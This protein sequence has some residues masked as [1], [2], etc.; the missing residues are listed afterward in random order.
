M[1]SG[2]L[3]SDQ[4]RLFKSLLPNVSLTSFS[5]LK[6]DLQK[7]KAIFI[8]VGFG[9]GE[10]I[11]QLATLHKDSLFIGCEAFV[12]G[13][14]AL[15]VKIEKFNIENIR[16]F[17]GDARLL[18]SEIPDG[19]LEG[20]F[21]LFPDPWPKRRH[22][23]RRILQSDTIAMIHSKLKDGGILRIATD[24]PEY[25]LWIK[26]LITHDM[27]NMFEVK[28]FD[29]STRP[30]EQSWPT[31]RYECKATDDILYVE[32]SRRRV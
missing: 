2:K 23:K 29:R 14:A 4:E 10:H 19:L 3:T 21:I 11:A 22:I 1:R 17:Y 26:R 8:E 20:V 9:C 5:D 32:A 27:A 13:V 30:D 28:S 16:I 18:I 25:Q 7:Y 31:T 12:N 24:H 15:L 6:D